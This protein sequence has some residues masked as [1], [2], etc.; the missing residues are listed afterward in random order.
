MF[1]MINQ[2]K[3]NGTNP[4][5]MLKQ[6]VGNSNPEQMQNII[7]Q[8]KSMGCPKVLSM[9]DLEIL[10]IVVAAVVVETLQLYSKCQ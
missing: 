9:E 4:Q 2:A 8:A 1:Q 10:E 5:D 7:Q 6:M 3:N